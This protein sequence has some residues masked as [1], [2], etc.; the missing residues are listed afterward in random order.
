MLPVLAVVAS[1]LAD[2]LSCN[3]MYTDVLGK[4]K[5]TAH[6]KYPLPDAVILAVTPEPF[7]E[8]APAPLRSKLTNLVASPLTET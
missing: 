4:V 1:R 7:A 8:T 5:L 2:K 6:R 3:E